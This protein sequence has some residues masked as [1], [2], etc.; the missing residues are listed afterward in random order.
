MKYNLVEGVQTVECQNFAEGR[1]GR[2]AIAYVIH[3]PEDTL[4]PLIT[5]LQDPATQKSYHYIVASDGRI[6]NLVDP[7]NTAW[8]VGTVVSPTW[9]GIQEG[10]NPNLYTI[11]IALEGYAVEPCTVKQYIAL[12]KLLA[13]LDIVYQNG[14]NN[15]TVVFHREIDT[16]KACP[17]FS[18]E[19]YYVIQAAEYAYNVFN[20]CGLQTT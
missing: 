14:L 9:L 1:E 20:T 3:K 8:A 13:D 2:K 17:G 11:S 4:D 10:V 12:A 19:K 6:I 15:N 18:I 7:D 16:A 5:Y